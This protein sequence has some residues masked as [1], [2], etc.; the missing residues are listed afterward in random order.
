ME[1]FAWLRLTLDGRGEKTPQEKQAGRDRCQQGGSRHLNAAD[2]QGKGWKAAR[3]PDTMSAFHSPLFPGSCDCNN[4]LAASKSTTNQWPQ[5]FP[6]TEGG[7]LKLSSSEGNGA[8]A[9]GGWLVGLA[10]RRSR[11]QDF[12]ANQGNPALASSVF[13]SRLRTVRTG[14]GL[15]GSIP[16]RAQTRNSTRRRRDKMRR[17]PSRRWLEDEKKKGQESI[18]AEFMRWPALTG[19]P[20]S[21]R[22]LSSSYPF[23]PFCEHAS[24]K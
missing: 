20:A 17:T 15:T 5:E 18:S 11:N 6:Q 23:G 22:V 10:C 21:A 7:S 2:R 16:S 24:T 19:W 1:Q 12:G 9:A 4:I 8:Q 13:L 3:I 14:R